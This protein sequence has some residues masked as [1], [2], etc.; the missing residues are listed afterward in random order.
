MPTPD[1]LSL[2]QKK[3]DFK[4]TPEPKPVKHKAGTALM[5]VIQKHAASH[6]HYDLRLE[7]DGEISVL[8][9]K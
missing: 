9:K 5:F 2:Y 6:L 8:K 7:S 3:R 4:N 1:S